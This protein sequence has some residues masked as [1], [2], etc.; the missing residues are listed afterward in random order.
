MRLKNHGYETPMQ[1]L[2]TDSKARC[3][4]LNPPHCGIV[5]LTNSAKL[6]FRNWSFTNKKG[7]VLITLIIAMVLM[8][9]LGLAI[10]SIFTS[11]SFSE[12]LSNRNDNAYQLAKSGIR[13][14]ADTK[15]TILGDFL[16]PDNSKK[17][18]LAKNGNVITSTGI[19]NAGTFLEAR[20]VLT[21]TISGIPD[22]RISDL[23]TNNKTVGT[24][25]SIANDG[26]TI[27]LGGTT[28]PGVSQSYGAIWYN[29]NNSSGNCSSGACSF[30]LGLRA[31]FEF[32]FP[33]SHNSGDGF[34]FAVMSALTN[35]NDR[36]GGF[37]KTEYPESHTN[38]YR[39]SDGTYTSVAGG[40]LM[41]YAGP[42]NTYNKDS[43]N[44]GQGLRPSKMA[45]EFDT[46][47]NSGTTT[48]SEVYLAGTRN[49]PNLGTYGDHVA[50]MFWGDSTVA[51]N[52]P[53]LT[54]SG[55]GTR[56]LPLS[57]FDDNRHGA[58]QTGRVNG[59]G[60]VGYDMEDGALRSC[61]IEITRPTSKDTTGACTTDKYKYTI[62]AWIELTSALSALTKSRLQD[63][64]VPFTDTATKISQNACFTQAEHDNFANIF[65]GFT[66]G[67]GDNVQ[68][69]PIT[70]TVVFF[71]NTASACTYTISTTPPT[72][73]PSATYPSTGGSGSFA[74]TTAGNCYWSV[75][76][77]ANWITITSTP[78]YG[79]GPAT[80]SY[81]VAAN[82]GAARSGYINIA[83]QSFQVT[84][85][86]GCSSLSITTPSLPTGRLG[87]AYS[88]TIAASGVTPYSWSQSGLPSGLSI[89]A[90]TGLISGTP[91]ANGWFTPTV[92]VTDSCP[93]TANANY[94]LGIKDNNY[95]ITNNTGGTIYRA[96]GT[97]CS[98]TINNGN[99]SSIAYNSAAVTFYSSRQLFTN[100]CQG[101]S[102]SIS[103]ASADAVDVN[104]SGSVQIN[105]A[106]S[107]ID[108]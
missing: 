5:Q 29:G 79:L 100:T 35:T 4:V 13:F 89:N 59:L 56:I 102:I 41:G 54:Y 83:G 108:N 74:L 16:M 31:Y 75:S 85:A 90:S 6:R 91:S 36:T 17:F 60:A 53:A 10:Y 40:E 19:V 9:V 73:P 28:S 76:N 78:L 63:V 11:S 55:G 106:W 46:Y 70:N 71:P 34:T 22:P 7:S 93:Q 20:R 32:S 105:S 25:G 51:S 24:T 47:L 48:A 42:G 94:S 61:R 64:L 12:L 88:T 26:T 2:E 82:T 81:T 52:T 80:I 33:N 58:G 45:V 21:Y 30:N 69:V 67:T 68:Q 23:P 101:T 37:S 49:D 95:T 62:N 77:L 92:T 96:S 43:S 65:W 15:G 44:D 99:A 18:N 3:G 66:E 104:Y 87:I 84:Q 86:S 72:S 8:A 57:S 98:T 107:L 38:T 39:R 1:A 97:N 14:A 50:L 27:T 103:G